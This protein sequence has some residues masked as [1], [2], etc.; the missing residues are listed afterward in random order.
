MCLPSPDC[1]AVHALLRPVSRSQSGF[2]MSREPKGHGHDAHSDTV[3]A[4]LWTSIQQLLV[5]LFQMVVERVGKDRGARSG[6]SW[7]ELWCS[8]D[9]MMGCDSACGAGCLFNS[10]RMWIMWARIPELLEPRGPRMPVPCISA[11]LMPRSRRWALSWPI[12]VSFYL[13]RSAAPV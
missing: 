11:I 13:V 7:W 2:S 8:R 1:K 5:L 6:Q 4:A 3:S 12:S 10:T 9:P